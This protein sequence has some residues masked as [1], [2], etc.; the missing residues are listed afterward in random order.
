MVGPAAK[1]AAVAHLQD[2]MGLSERRACSIV[3]SS[4]R[5][6]RRSGTAPAGRRTRSFAAGCAS[7]PMIGCGS[8]IAGCS[9]CCGGS[10]SC[11]NQPHPPALSGRRTCRTQAEG[12]SQGCRHPRPDPGSWWRRGLTR[13]GHSTSSMTSSPMDGAS[14]S[15]TSS[16][17]SRNAL[18]RS[19][20]L[21]RRTERGA[22][23][24]GN[25]REPLQTGLDCLRPIRSYAERY[26]PRPVAPP[27]H[28]G[29]TCNRDSSHCWAKQGAQTIIE[30]RRY[31]RSCQELPHRRRND[32][33]ILRGQHQRFAGRVQH[34][35]DAPK[36]T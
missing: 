22:R 14:A 21:N 1:R 9:S 5:T 25:R 23:T 2:K 7:L 10:A 11:R 17:M 28:Y 26:A 13:A 3:R 27:S 34:H 16:T 31:G 24:G 8:V 15:S 12:P 29:L 32:S 6:G 33:E 4:V 36:R 30:W 18:A 35:R 19:R 20:H